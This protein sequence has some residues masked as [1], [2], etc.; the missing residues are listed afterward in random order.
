MEYVENIIY[1]PF[2]FTYYCKDDLS[3]AIK[4]GKGY[5]KTDEKISLR[6]ISY[7][8]TEV[9]EEIST[10]PTWSFYKKHVREWLQFCKGLHFDNKKNKV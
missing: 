1:N 9:A 2:N 6:E 7:Y 4:T 8:A 5:L 3:M 10:Y